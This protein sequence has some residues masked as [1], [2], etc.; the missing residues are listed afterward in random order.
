MNASHIVAEFLRVAGTLSH[1]TLLH[2]AMSS[3]TEDRQMR[4]RKVD[5]MELK[6]QL[7]HNFS[8]GFFVPKSP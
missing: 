3:C 5:R 1:G 6:T 4:K 2:V 8:Q 7:L